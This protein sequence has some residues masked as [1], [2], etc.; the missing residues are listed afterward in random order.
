MVPVIT[1]H[2][3]SGYLET[4]TGAGLITP[5]Q[6]DAI[7]AHEAAAGDRKVPRW[8]EPVAYLGAALVAL[9]LILFGVSV[10]DQLTAWSRAG[11]AGLITLVLLVAGWALS[12]SA[13]APAR[14]AGS[15]AWLLSV[16][17]VAATA[18]L[19]TLDSLDL[20][21]DTVVL[22]TAVCV[23]SAAAVLYLLARTAL[24][25]IALAAGIVFLLVALGA[26]VFT[27]DAVWLLSLTLFALGAI[28]LLLT[29][30][31]FL[32]PT[33]TGWVLGALLCLGVGFAGSEGQAIWSGLGVAVGLGIV[34]LS[35]LIDLRAL[36]GIGVLGLVVWIPTTV[37]QVFQGTVAVPVAI[38]ITGVVALTVVV[39]AV[40]HGR[41]EVE[42]T[43][44][45]ADLPDSSETTV[46]A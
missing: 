16:G 20:D 3:L 27:I 23:A 2:E 44:D 6:A 32:K 35:T 13:A 39:A 1:R 11:I 46:D 36:L 34:Y 37:T 30:G 29:W 15:F 25:Q 33:T 9:S 42:E 22:S 5:E 31:G 24:Q 38:L 17:G 21:E 8:V 41:T 43:T 26:I 45:A 19:V 7:S 18:V 14:R 12:R 40:R 4:W 10:W 28:W